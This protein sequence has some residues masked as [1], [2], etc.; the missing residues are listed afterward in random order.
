M[1]RTKSTSYI[2]YIFFLLAVIGSMLS[3]LPNVLDSGYS[4][5]LQ[6]LWIL[7]IIVTFVR[8]PKTFIS[9]NILV[10]LFLACLFCVYCGICD[11]IFKPKYIGN[12]MT[13]I[14]LSMAIF[15]V[16]YI[17]WKVYG[18]A[19]L[20]KLFNIVLIICTFVLSSYVYTHFLAESDLMSRIYAFKAKNS[21]GLILFSAILI[22]FI[23]AEFNNKALKLFTW[24]VMAYSTVIIFMLKSRA[25]LVS[26][27]F[28]ILYTIFKIKNKSI[29]RYMIIGS[30]LFFIYLMADKNFYD[31]FVNGIL[32]NTNALEE[33]TT[34]E[35]DEISS[36]R[37]HYI[38]QVLPLIPDNL[39]FGIG[40][41]YVDCMPIIMIAQYGLVGASFVFALIIFFWKNV[42]RLN[43]S[44]NLFLT[45]FLLLAS[46]LINSLF[47]AYPPFGPGA[48]CF[49]LWVIVG[50]SFAEKENKNS[51]EINENL[52]NIQ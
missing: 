32:L 51:I 17:I 36:G 6:A 8:L 52:S 16:S 18:S 4:K 49:L 39:W 35:I 28:V 34:E 11:T 46:F 15:V 48:K 40:N 41:K 5:Y 1:N 45:A 43:K 24:F 33:I 3:Q 44:N 21:L 12:D 9:R 22:I 26:V 23:T 14:I 42:Y 38:S 50:F 19:K 30:I 37:I 10:P 13:N 29:R 31:I 25:T 7:P 20:L 2:V 47:E 27:F